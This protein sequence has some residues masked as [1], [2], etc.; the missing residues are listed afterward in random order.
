MEQKQIDK[1]LETI[2]WPS[3]WKEIGGSSSGQIRF[4]DDSR[5]GHLGVVFSPDGDAWISV[6]P[7]NENSFH[8]RT[9]RFRNLSGGGQS[10]RVREA[11]MVLAMAISADNEDRPQHR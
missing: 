4:E 9:L 1:I 6:I 7:D 2:D 3:A 10:M 11:L 8:N 5:L